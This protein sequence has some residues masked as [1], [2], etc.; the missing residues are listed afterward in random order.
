MAALRYRI[1]EIKA[2]RI[3]YVTD[4]GQEL[5]FKLVFAGGQVAGFYDPKEK[6][7]D[8]MPFGMVLQENVTE[9]EDGEIVKKA[10][11]IKTREGKSTKLSELLD[12]AKFRALKMFDERLQ[13]QEEG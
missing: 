2:D 6:Q 1:N 8:H 4:I 9:N 3:V 13:N 10:E 11:K 5:H 12:E 7:V